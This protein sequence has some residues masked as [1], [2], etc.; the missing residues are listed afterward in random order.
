MV[1]TLGDLEAASFRLN[2]QLYLRDKCPNISILFS[3]LWESIEVAIGPPE[4]QNFRSHFCIF[5]R[6]TFIS[7]TPFFYSIKASCLIYP[8]NL[9][10]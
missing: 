7:N 8:E 9:F 1:A 3:H 6:S 5:D 4:P 2:F 10:V